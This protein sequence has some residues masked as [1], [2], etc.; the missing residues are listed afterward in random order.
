MR[1][2]ARRIDFAGAVYGGPL[3]T[4]MIVRRDIGTLRDNS[5]FYENQN[6]PTHQLHACEVTPMRHTHEVHAYEVH[7]DEMHA[8]EMHTREMYA[9]E[10]HARR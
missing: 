3:G 2:N 9:R 1:W 8:R 7:T 5:K 4:S 10:V 6:P